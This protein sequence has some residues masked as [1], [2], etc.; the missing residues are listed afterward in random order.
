MEDDCIEAGGSYITDANPELMNA[1]TPFGTDCPPPNGTGEVPPRVL[2][3][4]IT[5]FAPILTGTKYV[6]AH[7]GHYTQ[8]GWWVTVEF[9]FSERPDETS[10]KPPAPT[11]T[12]TTAVERI[13]PG[14]LCNLLVAERLGY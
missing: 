11:W 3:L 14:D 7:I 9:E 12:T 13:S 8:S 10:P 6:G 2:T 1:V 5:P 4:D